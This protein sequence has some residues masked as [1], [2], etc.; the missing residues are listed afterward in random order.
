M[1][2]NAIITRASNVIVIEKNRANFLQYLFKRNTDNNIEIT[3]MDIRSK[4]TSIRIDNDVKKEFLIWG[5]AVFKNR[6][7]STNI[8]L[9]S[10]SRNITKNSIKENMLTITMLT[11]VLIILI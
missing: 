2:F 9:L 5:I 4:I 1:S 7:N 10:T 3:I 11:E 8:P 6:S